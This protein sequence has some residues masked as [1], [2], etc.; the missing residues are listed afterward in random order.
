VAIKLPDNLKIDPEEIKNHLVGFIQGELKRTGFKKLVVGVS[1]GLDSAVVAT[2]S[3]HAIGADN[4]IG[5][6]MPY[7]SS[8]PENTQDAELVI[9]TLGINR[10]YV[11]ITPMV[12]V[13]FTAHPTEDRNR[14][15]NKMA[16]ERMSVLYDISAELGALVIGTSNKSEIK[17]GYGTLFGDLACALNPI[18]NLYKTQI[19]QLARYLNVPEKIITKAPSA[20][21]WEGQTDEGE[22]GLTYEMLDKFLFYFVDKKYDDKELIEL[23]FAADFIDRLKTKIRQN[24]FKGQLPVIALLP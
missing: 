24:E 1:G 23:G 18:G 10:R 6:I 20:D 19:R 16:R 4:V 12:D 22:L 9:K 5:V 7:S 17:M 11:E 13:Y 14:K 2:L 21:L 8:N 15:G 3:V